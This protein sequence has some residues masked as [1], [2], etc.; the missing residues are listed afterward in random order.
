MNF[1]LTS[2]FK[3]ITIESHTGRGIGRDEILTAEKIILRI[4]ILGA[5]GTLPTLTRNLPSVALRR[6]GEV[7]LFDCGEGTQ[8]QLM[9]ARVGFGHISVIC[10][11]HLHGDHV[12]GIPGLLMTLGQSSRDK[13]LTLYGPPGLEK[14]VYGVMDH[15]SIHPGYEVI[16]REGG[17]GLPHQ[18]DG[19]R[20]EAVPADHNIPTYAYAFIEN[21]RPGRFDVECMPWILARA[22][23][24]LTLL[25]RLIY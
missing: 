7:V 1:G 8:L 4:V 14:Y 12:T 21:R 23:E 18:G 2:R 6:E 11:S 17:A 9:K 25:Q 22:N 5:G 16:V 10:V 19:Y 20:I 15:I 24:S 3:C 13:A